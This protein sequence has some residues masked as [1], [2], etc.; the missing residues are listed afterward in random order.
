MQSTFNHLSWTV[1]QIYHAIN[2]SEQFNKFTMQSTFLNISTY[3]PCN[4]LFWTFQHIYHAVN[5][6]KQFNIFTMQLTFLNSSTYLQCNQ[7]LIIFLEHFNIFTMQ[8]TFLNSSTNL[9]CNQLFWTVQQIYHAINFSEQ[10]NIFT[11]Q[12]TF[13][14]SST[15]VICTLLQNHCKQ[16]TTHFAFYQLKLEPIL[17]SK[18][19]VIAKQVN[20]VYIRPTN[21]LKTPLSV[22]I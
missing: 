9:P 3:L 6:S 20:C 15:Y 2:F 17:S 18:I 16:D 19:Q 14:N 8:S 4:Q 12:S 5:F 22:S 21:H 11:M 10:F 13:L 1:Q 7:L